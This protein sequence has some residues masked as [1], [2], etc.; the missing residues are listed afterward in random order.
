[1]QSEWVSLLPLILLAAG[2]T[3]IFCVGAFWPRRPAGLLMGLALLSSAASGVAVII[4]HPSTTLLFDMLAADNYSRFYT[5]LFSAITFISLLF[6]FQYSIKRDFAGDEFYGIILF[7]AAGM[8]LIASAVHWLA[9][10]LGLEL[11][12]ICLYL[13]IAAPKGDKWASE[14]AVK[15]FIMGAVASA[16]LVFGIAM[17]YAAS[18]KLDIAGSLA[19][20]DNIDNRQ[21]ILLGMCLILVGIGFKISL[22]PFHLW[23]PDVY[24]G[25]P[26]PVTAFLST[27]SKV[28]IYAFLLR[29]MLSSADSI[30]FFFFPSSADSIGFFFFP[31][32]WIA[33]ASNIVVGN[34]TALS[35]TRLKRLLAY[36]SI[37]HMGYLLMALLAVKQNGAMAV[38][39]YSAV[40]A[41][42]DLGAF[43]T[44]GLLSPGQNDLDDLENYK[45]LGYRYP[46]KAAILAICLLSL[47]GMPPTAGFFGK[48]ILFQAALGANLVTLAVVGILMAIV[49]LYFYLKV[50]VLLYMR[51]GEQEI[52]VPATDASGS[53]ACALI[54]ILIFWLGLLPSAVLT[55]ITHIS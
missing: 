25:A 47:A 43:G 9:F 29:L 10:F 31:V 2:G 1:M 37:A 53:L 32:L 5:V 41:V 33:A 50:V 27:G 36:S 8:V 22:V 19:I 39:F 30:G 34:L 20:S 45:G 35:Q 52:A 6:A 11:L 17:L 54:L 51:T 42:M 14:A 26:S 7:A 16:F 48:F 23:T 15:Y 3:A 44:V 12:S 24:Q 13:L 46:W 18:G 55:V 49:S 38:M 4:S 40:Y 21:L 28:A